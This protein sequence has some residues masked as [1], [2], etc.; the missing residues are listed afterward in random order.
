MAE[1]KKI[2]TSGSNAELAQITASTG[3]NGS[4]TDISFSDT[5]MATGDA[6]VFVDADC[7]RVTVFFSFLYLFFF[8]N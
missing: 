5:A 7:D 8:S 3:F 6:L 4:G 1:W 2:I